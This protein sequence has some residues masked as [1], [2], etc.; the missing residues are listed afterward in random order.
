[1]VDDLDYVDIKF[2]VQKRLFQDWIKE[3]HLH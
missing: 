2:S 1:M 3:W